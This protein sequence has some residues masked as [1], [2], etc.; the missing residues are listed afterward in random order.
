MSRDAVAMTT[1]SSPALRAKISVPLI[2]PR[3]QKKTRTPQAMGVTESSDDRET[4][5]SKWRKM[6]DEELHVMNA[7]AEYSEKIRFHAYELFRHGK[8]QIH[9]NS[10]GYSSDGDLVMVREEIS[11][12][13]DADGSVRRR[14]CAIGSAV[15]LNPAAKRPLTDDDVA[16]GVSLQSLRFRKYPGIKCPKNKKIRNRI[17]NDHFATIEARKIYDEARS[18]A[19]HGKVD[20]RQCRP[21][22]FS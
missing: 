19:A 6:Q 3:Y 8:H 20:T 17:M 2:V 21:S 16:Q 4:I 11:E 18:R 12:V 1:E 15:C 5:S 13:S 9:S 14:L 7:G 10:V 22:A